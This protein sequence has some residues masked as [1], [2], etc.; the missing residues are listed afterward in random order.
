MIL[1]VYQ[2]KKA[3]SVLIT[4]F[5]MSLVV[6]TYFFQKL[7]FLQRK[8]ITHQFFLKCV[9]IFTLKVFVFLWQFFS[10]SLDKIVKI[11]KS[12]FVE[13]KFQWIRRFVTQRWSPSHQVNSIKHTSSFC[14]TFWKTHLKPKCICVYRYW[15]RNT[16]Q[17]VCI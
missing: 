14:Y 7:Y 3:P 1:N 5:P 2:L 12:T 16:S 4:Q 8:A 9:K 6:L 15:K 17:W 10:I 13:Q 11:K